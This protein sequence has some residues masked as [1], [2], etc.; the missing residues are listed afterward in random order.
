MSRALAR[1]RETTGDPLLVRAG[2]GLV[3][4]PRALELQSLVNQLVQDAEAVL[5]PAKQLNLQQ[6]QRTFTLRT[7]DGF[8]EN[9]GAELIRRV[10]AAAPGVRL[11]F[12]A[13]V[14]KDNNALRDG[15]VDLETG[16]VDDSTGP[17]IRTRILFHDRF[18]GVVRNAHPLCK[19][20]VTPESY[21]AAGHIRVSRRGP[22][23]GS[24]DAALHSL[25]LTR[26]I[27]TTVASFSGALAVARA[28]D[29]IVSLPERQTGK[30]RTG[31][32]SFALPFPLPGITISMLWHP[33]MDGDA[34]HRWLRSIILDICANDDQTNVGKGN[35]DMHNGDETNRA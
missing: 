2:R 8:V 26:Q 5:R 21:A 3:P 17:E 27:A 1:L 24:I 15:S 14:N 20:G 11:N 29:L 19:T 6:L 35:V 25:G 12:A 9:Y 16:I 7:R 34:A 30:L 33:R 31:M 18:V 23:K 22:T 28:S 10:S 4:T 32:H 13:K